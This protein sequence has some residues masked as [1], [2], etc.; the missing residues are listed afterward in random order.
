MSRKVELCRYTGKPLSKCKCPEGCETNQMSHNEWCQPVRKGYSLACCDCD[1]VHLLDF[2][3]HKGHIQFRAR[4]DEK[5]TR[6]LRK[7]DGIT[8]SGRS[9]G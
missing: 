3:I 1:L 9:K 2:R 7:Q 8:V 4:R 6:K 5:A